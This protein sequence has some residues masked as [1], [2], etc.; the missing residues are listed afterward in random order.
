MFADIS[1]KR[2][3]TQRQNLPTDR[4]IS[5]IP[6]GSEGGN[7]EYPSPQQ[8]YNA[9]I[10]KGYHD[11][12][13]DGIEAMVDVHNF[14]N[15]GAWAEIVE[16]ERRFSSGLMLGWDKCSRGEDSSMAGANL[17][18]GEEQDVPQPKLARFQGRPKDMTPKAAWLQM[19][20][21][22]FPDKFENKPPFDRHDWYVQRM[23]QNGKV[24]EVRYVID[25]Y[26]APPEP[27]GEP[28]FFL[29]V[30]PAIDSP[31]AAA[32]RMM[33]WYGDFW[34]RASGGLA[35]EAAKMQERI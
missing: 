4:T 21:R 13:E 12:P 16:W 25:Y 10:R 7:W 33:R 30:R 35:R 5:S 31:S 19:M 28:V 23:S 11:T 27:T 32:E 8:M 6:K 15:E 9:L 1:Q 18:T 22:L 29:D 34:W 17:G 3:P 20:A 26:D 14:L 24:Q 2:Q